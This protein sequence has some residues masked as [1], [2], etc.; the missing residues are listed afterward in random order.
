MDVDVDVD[1]GI[2]WS[3]N[4]FNREE[5]NQTDA[6]MDDSVYGRSAW[7]KQNALPID[8]SRP[9][10]IKFGELN[11]FGPQKLRLETQ[12]ITNFSAIRLA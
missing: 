1:V 6:D 8:K 10:I 9:Q 3:P 5:L 12:F 2:R 7:R 4:L 11:R